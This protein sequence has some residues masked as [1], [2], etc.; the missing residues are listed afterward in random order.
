MSNN[1]RKLYSD[2]I[3]AHNE[4]PVNFEKRPGSAALLKA[5]NPICGDRFE[6]FINPMPDNKQSMLKE[7][8]FHGFGCAISK[9][10]TSVMVKSLIGKS[11]ED[12]QKLCDQFLKFVRN[13][14]T[15]IESP[16]S[17]DFVAFSG[18]HDFP[19]RLDCATLAW[20]EMKTFLTSVTEPNN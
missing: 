5:Y 14:P 12:A 9:A 11:T 6:V 1:L 20:K 17:D 4:S 2:T 19:E 18:V 8:S 16:L 7:L 10:S 15:V 3:K 13:D